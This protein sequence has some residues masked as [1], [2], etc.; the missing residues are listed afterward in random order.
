MKI[1]KISK[2]N[3]KYRLVYVPS[4][5][6]KQIFR[7]LLKPLEE[8]AFLKCHSCVHGFMVGRSPVTNAVQHINKNYTLSFDIENFFDSVNKAHLIGLIP[9]SIIDKVLING[10]PKQGLPTSP[11]VCNIAATKFDKAILSLIADSNIVY[12]RYADDLTFSFDD[13][14]YVNVLKLEIPKILKRF[15]FSVNTKKTKLQLAKNGRRIITGIAVDSD[16]YPTR[17]TKRKLRAAIH[18]GNQQ[19][20]RGLQ[21]WN[22][23][24]MP[25]N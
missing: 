18:N 4:P 2:R 16:I 7:R 1:I 6:Q 14:N 25:L 24:K 12:T 15:D 21:E 23:L 11:V 9:E 10:S 19:K 20:I 8:I 22:D 13:Q 17:K 3:G 5:K